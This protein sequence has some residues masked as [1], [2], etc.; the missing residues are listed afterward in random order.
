MK[1]LIVAA[2]FISLYF[3]VNA[4]DLIVTSNGDSLNCKIDTAT[5]GYLYFTISD[6]VLPFTQLPLDHVK[7]CSRGYYAK[8]ITS[9]MLARMEGR[10]TFWL[11]FNLG[12]SYRYGEIDPQLSYQ[13]ERYVRGLKS[14][15]VLGIKAIYFFGYSSGIGL[16]Y[17]RFSTSNSMVNA[18]L[19]NSLG[20]RVSGD[21]SDNISISYLGPSYAVRLISP[22]MEHSLTACFGIGYMKYKD[23]GDYLTEIIITGES[24]GMLMDFGYNYNI[25]ENLAIGIQASFL[26]GVL[27]KCEME[28]G[29]RTRSVSLEEDKYESLSRADFSISMTIKL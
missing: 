2:I 25:S 13:M 10:K 27:T 7:L 26:L 15:A 17:S 21:V 20:G 16:N 23:V 24:L 29:G 12:F 5:S 8:N 9:G 28:Y 19:Y 18:P 6:G 11:S 14:G 1:R 4:Q 22:D 3:I